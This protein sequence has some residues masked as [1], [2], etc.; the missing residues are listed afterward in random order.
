MG[1]DV[2]IIIVTSAYYATCATGIIILCR[3]TRT[4]VETDTSR[5]GIV[6]MARAGALTPTLNAINN[7]VT[8]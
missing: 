7:V 3:N 1:R 6:I 2:A 8:L 5:Y 4:L